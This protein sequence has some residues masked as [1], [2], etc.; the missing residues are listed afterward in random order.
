MTSGIGRFWCLL[1]ICPILLAN[2]MDYSN[3]E[4]HIVRRTHLRQLWDPNFEDAMRVEAVTGTENNTVTNMTVQL[5]A[6]AYMH[7]HVRSSERELGGSGHK[8]HNEFP[9]TRTQHLIIRDNGDTIFQLFYYHT[10][11]IVK[12]HLLERSS[13]CLGFAGETGTS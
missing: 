1:C 10:K 4:N 5:G 3:Y 8:F 11:M 13:K 2:T 6:T 9:F 7:C 12:D